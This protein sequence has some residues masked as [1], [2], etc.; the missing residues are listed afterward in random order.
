MNKSDFKQKFL[1]LFILGYNGVSPSN[2]FLNLISSGLG[3]VIFFAENLKN[4]EKFKLQI[5]EFNK[6]ATIPLFLSIDQE[7]GLVERTIFLDKK[8]EYLTQNALSRVLNPEL[9]RKHYDILA[10]DLLDLG[11]NLDFAPVVDVNS[12]PNNPIIGIRSFGDNPNIVKSCA[13]E[14]LNVFKENHII[15]CGKHFPGHGDTAIDS[16]INM[17]CVDMEMDKFYINHLSCFYEMVKSGIDTI[18]VSHVYFPCFDEMKIPASLSENAVKIYLKKI[19]DFKGLVFSDDMVMG[20]IAKNYGLKESIL[21]ALNAGIDS[22]LFRNVTDELLLA[23]D[24]IVEIAFED[25][26]LFDLIVNAYNKIVDFKNKH[27]V[28]TNQIEFNIEKAQVEI[29][30]IARETIAVH[31]KGTLLPIS[32]DKKIK[33]ISFDNNDIFNLSYKQ[34]NL[35]DLLSGYDVSEIKYHLNPDENNINKVLSQIDNTDIVIFLSYNAHINTAQIDLFTKIQAP[36]ILVSC[37]L[38]YDIKHFSEANCILSLSSPKTPSFM[39]LAEML[40]K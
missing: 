22:L 34:N 33:V 2:E 29:N 37:A 16:H 38:D 6:L 39:A 20:G 35:K 3:G 17:P 4:R 7:G 1:Q 15:S 10:K 8:I 31:K 28:N 27:L 23:I 13:K 11:I 9:F 21:L 26:E 25:E 32:K 24:E 40:I 14:L 18:M 12:N 36:K 5:D 30:N 19:I